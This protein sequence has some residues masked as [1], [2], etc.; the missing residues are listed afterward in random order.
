[1]YLIIDDSTVIP[2]T[3]CEILDM[4]PE[5]KDDPSELHAMRHLPIEILHCHVNV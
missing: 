2:R 3:R 4:L 1:M 5:H